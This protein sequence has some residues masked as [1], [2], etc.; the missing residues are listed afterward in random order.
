MPSLPGVRAAETRSGWRWKPV[1]LGGT[2]LVVYGMFWVV[3]PSPQAPTSVV[4][5]PRSC[6]HGP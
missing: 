6:R 5:G 3:T 4:V 2:G 1:L